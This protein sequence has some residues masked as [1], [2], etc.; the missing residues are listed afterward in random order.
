MHYRKLILLGVLLTLFAIAITACTGSIGPQ[1]PAGTVGQS[2]PQGLAGP[3]GP[4]GSQGSA[5]PAG[6]QGPAGPA[7]KAG[8]DGPAGKA[9]ALDK[10]EDIKINLDRGPMTLKTLG[11]IQPG[12][13]TVMVE[14][15]IR[16]DN[17]WFA[18]QAGNWDMVKYQVLEMTEIQEVAEMTRPARVPML[19]AFENGFL[20]PLDKATDAKDLAAFTTAYDN[21]INGCNGCHA[22][23]SSADF[24]TYK[25]VKIIRPAAAHFQNVDWKGQ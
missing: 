25:F 3:P 10:P 2:G 24:K 17:A 20:V 12:L 11:E 16:F 4:A 9:A 21:A 1:G 23:S 7:G 5:G 22:A 15:G 13:G 6:T 19:K 14:Y 8:A 18:A